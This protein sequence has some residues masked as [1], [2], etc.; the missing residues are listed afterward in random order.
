ML[1]ALFHA[2]GLI[3][4]QDAVAREV[5]LANGLVKVASDLLLCWVP[6]SCDSE[7]SLVPK[8]VT[9]AFLAMGRLLQVDQK[10]NADI[11]ELLKKHDF[12][13]YQT[14]VLIDEDKQDKLLPAKQLAFD[15]MHAVL[16][17]CSTLTR[18]HS[19]AV[20]FLDAGGL[21]LLLS[22]P[23][24]SLFIG[25]D[26][27]SPTI[28]RHILEDSQTLQ[29]AMESEIRH[30][31]AAQSRCQVEMLGERPYIVLLKDKCKEKEKTVEKDKAQT[32]DGK[33]ALGN[34]NLSGPGN[35][36]GKLPDLNSK[37]VK[38]HRKPPHSFVKVIEPE[39]H[40]D[41][42][43]TSLEPQS[44]VEVNQLQESAA[45]MPE[46]PAENNGNIEEDYLPQPSSTFDN[47]AVVVRDIEA[48]SQESNG[49][50]VWMLKLEVL[51]ATMMAEKGKVSVD[52]RTRRTNA[53]FG[54]STPLSGRDASLDSVTELPENHRLEAD[55]VVQAG[56][57]LAN[58]DADSEPI[59]P[60]FLDLLPKELRAEVL[61]AQQGQVAQ[62][63]NADSQ[64]NGDIDPEFL[65]ALSPDIREEILAQQ[66]QR[67][68][69]S[70][71]LE[72][73]PVEMDTVFIIATFP[74]ELRE[75][76]QTCCLKDLQIIIK[77]TLFGTYPRNRRDESSRRGEE[78]LTAMVRL[79]RAVQPLYKGR[80]PRLLLNLCA[81]NET[82]TF[83]VKIFI[84][85][86]LLDMRKPVNNLI[87]SK[88]SYR[89]YGCHNHV[90]YSW[91]QSFDVVP[92]LVSRRVLETLTY[93]ARNH[94]YVAKILLHF[95][96]PQPHLH[97][98][99]N[100]DKARGKAVMIVEEDTIEGNNNQEGSFSIALLLNLLSQ[101]LYLRSIAHL[102]QLLNLL[103]VIIDNV[104]SKSGLSDV[105]GVS[106]AEQT[107]GPQISTS[108]A[109]IITGSHAKLQTGQYGVNQDPGVAAASDVEDATTSASQ[110][111]SSGG[112]LRADEKHLAFVKFSDKYR[113]LLNACIWQNPGLLK[114]SFSLMLK[115]RL[116]V[117]YQGEEGIDAGGLTREWYQ[118]LSR[119]IFDEG[120]LL[121][122]TVGKE[123]TFHPNPNSV[124]QTEH[125][126]YFKFVE[127][128]LFD[129]QLLDVHFIG[130]LRV[131]VTYNDI[132]AIDPD[133]FKNLKWMLEVTDYEL[134]PGGRNIRVTEENKHKYVNT[135]F[136]LHVHDTS[137]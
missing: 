100:L 5:A 85:L 72:G 44:K 49:S 136:S 74:S 3:F 115:G 39:K 58:G 60:A 125:L 65:A 29:Q 24:S 109:E 75:E 102:E 34:I 99:E 48:V 76:R 120:A 133:Y 91:P 135:L 117:R 107:S 43:I 128:A 77:R 51:M 93:L 104:K 80:L 64:N 116:T 79:F 137:R 41:R 118:L 57:Q 98:S 10:L 35:G 46:Y 25:F 55:Q 42:A 59:D 113:K 9:T 27:I 89:L 26:S 12:G 123:S 78:S 112:A 97:E 83:L 15:T 130:S 47:N 8:W 84:D 50:G 40:S 111:K 18:T 52:T 101:P 38:T 63:S 108:D 13:G 19:V 71:E 37:N 67:L 1:Y 16:Q 30:S 103:E 134:I 114:K 95:K 92:P 90:L 4:H 110:Q 81:N 54:S 94:P 132:E 73:Q 124:Y 31:V 56:E 126:S 119:V 28:F 6:S 122:T 66:A 21:P 53:S 11:A 70:K 2:L 96:V 127:K 105:S 62:P 23:A 82:R 33:A 68:H 86:L 69:Q 106:A 129:G 61:F 14:S 88:P 17:L 22:F 7:N 32:A 131:K 87:A 45:M 121:F 20:R 36:H